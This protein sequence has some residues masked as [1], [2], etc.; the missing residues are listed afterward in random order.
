[1]LGWIFYYPVIWGAL[2][3]LP[4]L[5]VVTAARRLLGREITEYQGWAILFGLFLACFWVSGIWLAP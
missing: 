2:A 5:G 1:M 4:V 3:G